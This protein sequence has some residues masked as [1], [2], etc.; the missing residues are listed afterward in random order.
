MKQVILTLFLILCFLPGAFA[1]EKPTDIPVLMVH[2]YFL[3]G[4][5]TWLVLKNR[6]IAAGWPKDYVM[7][8]SF[9]NVV[10][11]NPEHAQKIAQWVN[12]LKAKTGADKVN[13]VAHSMGALDVR[14]YIKYL[15]GYKNVNKVV[16]IAGANHGTTV[17]CV[18]ML[19]CGAS[20]MCRKS[21]DWKGNDF[22]R[23]INACDETPG[24]I[25]YTSIWSPSDEIIRPPESS[26]LDGAENIKI[27]TKLVGHGRILTISETGDL[28][29]K[30]LKEGGANDNGP[31]L[32]C[33]QCS[34]VSENEP[35]NSENIVGDSVE[36]VSDASVNDIEFAENDLPDASETVDETDLVKG[37]FQADIMP[38]TPK[39]A[40]VQG[41]EKDTYT[42]EWLKAVKTD[43]GLPV[44]PAGGCDQGSG[45]G[46]GGLVLVLLLLGLLKKRG[47]A[48]LLIVIS[49]HGM[50]R[51]MNRKVML[52]DINPIIRPIAATRM[53][54]API[55]RM[56]LSTIPGQPYKYSAN[57]EVSFNR[58]PGQ[59]KA[60]FYLYGDH[61]DL[62]K[63]GG[64]IQTRTVQ[65]CGGKALST[66]NG[67]NMWVS[68]KNCGSRKKIDITMGFDGQLAKLQKDRATLAGELIREAGDM[69]SGSPS[70]ELAFGAFA[71]GRG[72]YNYF[73]FYPLLA[74]FQAGKGGWIK[75]KS[76]ILGD[77]P[78]PDAAFYDVRLVLP[79]NMTAAV[80]GRSVSSSTQKKIRF[81]I[82][83]PQ[84]FVT[85]RLPLVISTG[86]KA[87]WMA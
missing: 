39:I 70:F 38:E 20:E 69:L 75:M 56:R 60:L 31:G 54:D 43:D 35:K 8:P 29:I 6:L 62:H 86:Y 21:D 53:K 9:D 72:F 23:N 25:L 24:D 57:L 33:L 41:C 51:P 65:A 83:G 13:L 27:H 58:P 71:Y 19:S 80:P 78:E 66:V 2:G 11:C 16:N 49:L 32:N 67:P 85:F 1:E 77:A 34:D 14:Y 76:N 5:A 59:D 28:V 7:N 87:V 61:P 64:K 73:G 42:G 40:E 50:A 36:S 46:T 12:E 74:S 79:K 44:K 52:R 15:C 47:L 82:Y 48:V 26:I 4:G 63:Q 55:Y 22:L 37:E 10:G 3:P 18:D 68:L 45:P 84:V 30:A 17:A 81:F